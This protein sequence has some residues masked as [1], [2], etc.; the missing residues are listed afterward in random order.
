MYNFIKYGNRI[1]TY[2]HLHSSWATN[3]QRLRK[4]LCVYIR[5]LYLWFMRGVLIFT[6]G[7]REP[8]FYSKSYL[9]FSHRKNQLLFL[10]VICDTYALNIIYLEL[11]FKYEFSILVLLNQSSYRAHTDSGKPIHQVPRWVLLVRIFKELIIDF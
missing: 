8:V 3:L 5:R 1:Y 2:H 11:Y 9:V 7:R 6:I 4:T 10:A